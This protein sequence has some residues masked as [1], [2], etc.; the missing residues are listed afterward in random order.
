M[1][2]GRLL[3]HKKDTPVNTI[4]VPFVFPDYIDG[5]VHSIWKHLDPAEHRL[6][7]ID[8]CLTHE[9]MPNLADK[10]HLYIKSYRNLGCSKAWNFGI[11]C[12]DTEYLT[13]MG[14]DT[15]I[16]HDKWWPEVYNHIEGDDLGVW[17]CHP[18]HLTQPMKVEG[19]LEPPIFDEAA[20]EET[21]RKSSDMPGRFNSLIMRRDVMSEL[22]CDP[23]FFFNEDLYP[24]EQVDGHFKNKVEDSGRH[25]QAI[26]FPVWHMRAMTYQSG[27]M[28]L[29]DAGKSHPSYLHAPN[30]RR[31]L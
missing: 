5:C 10:C 3:D 27:K 1:F 12:S 20:W 18:C 15:R 25:M 24:C 31:N 6:I 19:R 8:N 13:I 11:S 23:T 29:H 30:D 26:P 14:D 7:V 28:P 2:E 16:I 9:L 21:K 4:I 17:F 22:E